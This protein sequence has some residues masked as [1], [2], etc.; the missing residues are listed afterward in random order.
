MFCK[1]SLTLF[2]VDINLKGL[3][4]PSGGHNEVPFT[5]EMA[6]EICDFVANN[7]F[8]LKKVCRENKH[9]PGPEV[10]RRW[11]KR[12]P[13]FDKAYTRAKEEQVETDVDE[14]QEIDDWAMQQTYIDQFGN[15][16]IDSA[17]IQLARSKKDDIKWRAGKLKRKKYGDEKQENDIKPHAPWVFEVKQKD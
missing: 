3:D 8:G 9:F 14:M 7:A 2:Y 17:A 13:E 5:Q 12:Y 15:K 6:D 16:R 1:K 4:M 11:F 10:I